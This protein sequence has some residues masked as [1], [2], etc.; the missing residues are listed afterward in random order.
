MHLFTRFFSD[1]FGQNE[2]I[3]ESEDKLEDQR[4]NFIED[5]V[6]AEILVPE[7]NEPDKI[8]LELKETAVDQIARNLGEHGVVAESAVIEN[9]ISS[10]VNDRAEKVYLEPQNTEGDGSG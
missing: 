3:V 4:S 9:D 7:N 2:V 8:F 1:I 6:T 5:I 10:P